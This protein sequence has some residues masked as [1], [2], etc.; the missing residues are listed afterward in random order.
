MLNAFQ[1]VCAVLLGMSHQH[2]AAE[3]VDYRMRQEAIRFHQDAGLFR[4]HPK[5]LAAY[6]SGDA[7]TLAAEAGI[8]VPPEAAAPATLQSLSAKL[9]QALALLAKLEAKAG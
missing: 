9:D 4:G 5:L 8:D 1:R 2:T 7:D 3:E 6:N